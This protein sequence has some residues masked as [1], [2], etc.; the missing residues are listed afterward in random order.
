MAETVKLKFLQGG[1]LITTEETAEKLLKT[2][3]YRRVVHPLP[4]ETAA[5]ETNTEPQGED[6]PEDAPKLPEPSEGQEKRPEPSVVRAWAKENGVE[7]SAKGRVSDE[8]YKQYAEA[9][10][11]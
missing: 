10:K 1:M 8:V 6:T 2:G 9:H 5:D 4:A 3:L 7:V 11:E